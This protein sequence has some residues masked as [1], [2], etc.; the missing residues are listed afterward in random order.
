MLDRVFG[1]HSFVV[2]VLLEPM[3]DR[4]VQGPLVVTFVLWAVLTISG[5]VIIRRITRGEGEPPSTWRYRSDRNDIPALSDALVGDISV[6]EPLVQP[7]D[8]DPRVDKVFRDSWRLARRGRRLAW[9]IFAGTVSVVALFALLI[10]LGPSGHTMMTPRL[11]DLVV[12]VVG[13]IGIAVG[14]AWMWRILRADPEPDR[15]GWL[16]RSR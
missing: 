9:L 13:V 1:M 4:A 8:V 16:Y 15:N 7:P 3:F 10:L 12:P 2:R 14:L 5:F 11:R 6:D